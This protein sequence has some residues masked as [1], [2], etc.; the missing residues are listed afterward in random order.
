MQD[1]QLTLSE[2]FLYSALLGGLFGLVLGILVFYFANRRGKKSLGLTG[3]VITI[4]AG[5]LSPLLAV[6]SM[7]IFLWIVRRNGTASAGRGGPAP[8]GPA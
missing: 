4:I 2:F 6:V 5:A 1:I 8:N 3:L 7:A